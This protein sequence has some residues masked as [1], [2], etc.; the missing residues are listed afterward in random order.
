MTSVPFEAPY[1]LE[2]FPAFT[3]TITPVAA[4]ETQAA[5]GTATG[6]G[7]STGVETTGTKG[8]GAAAATQTGKSAAVRRVRGGRWGYGV[9]VVV[10]GVAGGL[11]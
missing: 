11:V 4:G 5:K 7:T 8:T 1:T 6:K 2:L 10:A 3:S 9:V